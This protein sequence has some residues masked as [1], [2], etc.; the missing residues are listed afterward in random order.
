MWSAPINHPLRRMFAGLTEH[1]FIAATAPTRRSSIPSE[2]LT[3]SRTSG[4]SIACR[5][6][7][8]AAD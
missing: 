8:T 2:L 6:A 4:P 3:G 1:A 5:F 7:R